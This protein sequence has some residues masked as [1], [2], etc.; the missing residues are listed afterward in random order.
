MCGPA[1]RGLALILACG[2]LVSGSAPRP[3]SSSAATGFQQPP[4]PCAMGIFPLLCFS[5]GMPTQPK[6]GPHR[7]GLNEQSLIMYWCIRDLWGLTNLV[8]SCVV[9]LNNT[10]PRLWML[11]RIV[12]GH[13]QIAR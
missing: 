2:H 7:L 5:L 3:T 10:L 11:Y 13:P 8:A 6:M 4:P 12:S 9:E 1:P